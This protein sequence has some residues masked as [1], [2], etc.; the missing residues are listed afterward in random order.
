MAPPDQFH[1]ERGHDNGEGALYGWAD[2]TVRRA[3]STGGMRTGSW[4]SVAAPQQDARARPWSDAA[5]LITM[6]AAAS[7]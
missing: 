1:L 4:K 5:G 3:P 7:A 6:A 2:D